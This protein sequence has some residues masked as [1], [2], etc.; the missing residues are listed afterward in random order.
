MENKVT[1]VK[2]VK[3][4][5]NKL[6]LAKNVI[7]I[8]LNFNDIR[9]SETE[10]TVLAYFMLYGV[11]TQ[12]KELIVKSQ[13]CKNLNNIKIVMVKL[14]RMEFIYKD[15]LNGKV[16]VS[17]NLRYVLTPTLGFYLKLDTK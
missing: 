12:T 6:D 16:Y 14:K 4:V 7:K 2:M 5:A 8:T 10:I 1:L 15:D 13:V 3:N 11:S 17:E 9:L